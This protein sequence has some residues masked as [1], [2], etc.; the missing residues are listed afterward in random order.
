MLIYVFRKV[1]D[2]YLFNNAL[3]SMA[4]CV[5]K[6]IAN[7]DVVPLFHEINLIEKV[8]NLKVEDSSINEKIEDLLLYV[9]F[10]D[11]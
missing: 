4:L 8:I 6:R 5:I 3:Q 10:G 2:R 7:D 9:V 1:G 11:L